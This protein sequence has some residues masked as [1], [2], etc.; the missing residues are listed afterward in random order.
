MCSKTTV[1]CGLGKVSLQALH[2]YADAVVRME[3]EKLAS[4]SLERAY[5]QV[6][7][8]GAV[9]KLATTYRRQNSGM[10]LADL[11]DRSSGSVCGMDKKDYIRALLGLVGRGQ[12]LHIDA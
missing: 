9:I 10:S 1:A 7:E 11:I 4:I 5:E 3:P 6:R 12:G 2:D 8:T